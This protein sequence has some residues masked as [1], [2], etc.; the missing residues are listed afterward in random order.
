[1]KLNKEQKELILSKR[2]G[3]NVFEKERQRF[4]M[5]PAGLAYGELYETLSTDSK[6]AWTILNDRAKLSKRN[7][8]FD[9]DGSIYFIFNNIDLVKI[10]KM[11][12]PKVIKIK[13][14]LVEYGLL[15]QKR[16]GRG[17]PNRLYLFEPV[18]TESDIHLMLKENSDNTENLDI[19][20]N[21]NILSSRTKNSLVLD[22]ADTD[23]NLNIL[24]SRT[25]N[26][27][28]LELNN[29]KANN[30]KYINNNINNINESAKAESNIEL[31]TNQYFKKS[32]LLTDFRIMGI[33]ESVT[34]EL[35][36]AI[37]D[38]E[39][40][41]Y[42]CGVIFQAKRYVSNQTNHEIYLEEL[43]EDNFKELTKC[44]LR[45]LKKD[46]T[47]NTVE[48]FDRYL[49]VTIQK[50]FENYVLEKKAQVPLVDWNL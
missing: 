24:S 47:E 6:F 37:G 17:L 29:F 49:F 31:S 4:L 35:Y 11:S 5:L 45:A 23:K 13:K 42:I 44:I 21:L 3:S 40:I 9:E 15:E 12:E 18:L 48:K 50:F 8:W 33:P 41:S 16:L 34:N 20:Q 43:S 25:K 30:N 14:E 32:K 10:L 38:T 7:G 27:S 28:V 39:K 36:R 46:L 2:V 26:S 19:T 22:N 1:M